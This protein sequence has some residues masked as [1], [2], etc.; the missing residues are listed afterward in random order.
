M[1]LKLLFSLLLP[2]LAGG[3]GSA[4]TTPAIPTWYAT[5]NK[6]VWQP[7]SW[8]FGPVWTTLYFLM[9]VAFFLVIKNQSLKKVSN[10]VAIFVVQLIFN[11]LWS[12]VFFGMKNIGGALGVIAILWVLIVVNILI[13]YRLNKTAG[14]LLVPYLLW[15]SFASFLNY[16]IWTLN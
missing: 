12:I 4:F 8:L 5:L 1:I 16:T 7:P 9:G 11:A 6:P 2:F 10:A 3:L 15:V 14:I 13:F